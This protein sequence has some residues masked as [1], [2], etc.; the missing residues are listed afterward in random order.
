M[1]IEVVIIL[2]CFISI[3]PLSTRWVFNIN[4][5]WLWFINDM[6]YGLR[7]IVLSIPIFIR[8]KYQSKDLIDVCNMI[9]FVLLLFSNILVIFN[10]YKFIDKYD[11]ILWQARLIITLVLLLS[12]FYQFKRYTNN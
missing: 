10:D 9:M 6:S 2:Y 11:N 12:S 4:S 5:T 1:R 7:V 3:F 8:I